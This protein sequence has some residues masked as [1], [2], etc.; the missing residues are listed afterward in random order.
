KGYTVDMLRGIFAEAGIDNALFNLGGNVLALGQKPDGSCWRVGIQHPEGQG[1]VGVAEL[2]GK[3][4]IT[5]GGYERFFEDEDGN[6]WWHIMDPATGY[7]AKSGLISVTVM[8]EEGLYCDA[9]STALFIMGEE[10]AE[11]FWKERGDFDMALITDDGR[12]ILTPGL[13][14]IFTPADDCGYEITV[15]E[16]A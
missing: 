16:N 5:S 9:L 12:L 7:P 13:D 10:K 3:A 15:I 4:L 6:V 14:E 8:G 1:L 11:S 2:S